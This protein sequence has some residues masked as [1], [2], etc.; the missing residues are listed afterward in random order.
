MSHP[1]KKSSKNPQIRHAGSW[2]SRSPT[3]GFYLFVPVLGLASAHCRE[4]DTAENGFKKAGHAELIR[5]CIPY[6]QV[7]SLDVVPDCMP[8]PPAYRCKCQSHKTREVLHLFRC[9]TETHTHTLSHVHSHASIHCGI[10]CG[11]HLSKR[12]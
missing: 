7:A 2:L 4:I 6:N 1:Q 10:R 3:H 9:F 11:F 8:R 5:L 12:I